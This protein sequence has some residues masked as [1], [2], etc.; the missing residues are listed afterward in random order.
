LSYPV[1]DS[2]RYLFRAGLEGSWS[3]ESSRNDTIDALEGEALAVVVQSAGTS[4]LVVD[5]YEGTLLYLG[6]LLCFHCLN[7]ESL[8]RA[9]LW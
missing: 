4:L 5:W 6:R 8:R 1:T 2:G 7:S 3:T 9:R